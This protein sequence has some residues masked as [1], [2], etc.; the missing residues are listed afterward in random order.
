MVFLL[1]GPWRWPWRLRAWWQGPWEGHGIPGIPVAVYWWDPWHTIYSTMDPSWVIILYN[2]VILVK[3]I[4]IIHSYIVI[5]IYRSLNMLFLNSH[6]VCQIGFARTPE[7]KWIDEDCGARLCWQELLPGLSRCMDVEH[8]GTQ[9]S[10]SVAKGVN[11]NFG[12]I[13]TFWGYYSKI[14]VV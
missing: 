9:L 10:P 4:V 6:R 14:Y 1:P 2:P 3:V 12:F 5:M 13:N 11:R 7:M 8:S